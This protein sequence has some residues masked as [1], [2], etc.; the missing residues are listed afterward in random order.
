MLNLA[1]LLED[2]ARNVPDRIAVICG[3][4]ELTYKQINEKANQV[5]NALKSCGIGKGDNVALSCP[6][7]PFFPMI[8]YGILKAGATVVPLNILLKG[9]EIAYHLEDSDAKVY[10]CFEGS[11]E[12][13]IGEEGFK[14]FT[15]TETCEKFILLT[16]DERASTE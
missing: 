12:L 11:A 16:L 4:A 8:Y 6:N 10:F 1:V 15:A 3:G 2:S 13:P 5:A 14:G 9:R 7:I